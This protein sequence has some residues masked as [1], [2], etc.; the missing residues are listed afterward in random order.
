MNDY[1]VFLEFIMN[2][3]LLPNETINF[4][5][6]NLNFKY[7]NLNFFLF[8]QIYNSFNTYFDFINSFLFLN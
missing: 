5:L 6:I 4:N 3:L 8:Y 7:L 2:N 1:V